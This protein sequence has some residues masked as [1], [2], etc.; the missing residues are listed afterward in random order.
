[1]RCSEARTLWLE[2]R[3]DDSLKHTLLLQRYVYIQYVI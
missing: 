3:C 1:M 2:C